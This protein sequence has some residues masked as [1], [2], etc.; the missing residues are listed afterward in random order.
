MFLPLQFINWSQDCKNLKSLLSSKD[1]ARSQDWVPVTV[2]RAVLKTGLNLFWTSLRGL[3]S[4]RNNAVWGPRQ[5]VP[6]SDSNFNFYFWKP[7]APRRW[8][9]QPVMSKRLAVMVWGCISTYDMGSPLTWRGIICTEQY[10][11][12]LSIHHLYPLPT[13]SWKLVRKHTDNIFSTV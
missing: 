11:R 12:V 2:M 3:M 4:S 9:I 13:F 1:E 7:R 6:R 10:I 8:T 5:Q